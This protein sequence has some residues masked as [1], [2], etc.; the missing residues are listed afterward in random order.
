MVT[1][2]S[3]YKRMRI[4]GSLTIEAAIVIPLYVVAFAALLS[5]GNFMLFHV[6]MQMAITEEAKRVALR[7]NAENCEALSIIKDET[8]RILDDEKVSYSIVQ[9][10]IDGISFDGSEIDSGEYIVI[11]VDYIFAPVGGNVFGIF[12]I[13]VSQKCVMHNWCGYIS[14]YWD[15]D[16]SQ[17]YVYVTNNSEV[18]HRNRECS[19]IRLSVQSVKGTEID[20]LRNEGGAKYYPC[21]ICHADRNSDELY[22]TKD[23]NRYHMNL[24]CSGLKRTVKAIRISEIGERRPCSRCAR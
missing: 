11:K 19:H 7:C 6:K 16:Y 21:D 18:Y 9:N 12:G 13:P 23:G 4:E 15:D 5:I 2:S 8:L 22:I 14:G 1:I 17:D 10:G 3:V 20:S 24:T